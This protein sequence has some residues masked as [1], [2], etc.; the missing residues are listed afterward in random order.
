MDERGYPSVYVVD[1]HT[2]RPPPVPPRLG[3]K[4]QHPGAVQTL[5]FLLVSLAL[6]GMLIEAFLIYRLHKSESEAS[7]SHS[8]QSGDVD[9]YSK[10]SREVLPSKPVAHLTGGQDVVHKN[11]VM[12]W[13]RNPEPLLHEMD[14]KDRSLII[15]RQGYYNIYSKVSFFDINPFFHA[16]HVRTKL[17]KGKSIPLLVSRTNTHDSCRKEIRDQKSSSEEAS[18]LDGVD[19]RSNSYLSGVFHFF[20]DDAIFVKVSNTSQIVGLRAYEN[21]FG[22]YMI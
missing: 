7:G 6:C 4:R 15:Q 12:A 20:K 14:Y 16:I 10:G 3:Q 5:L 8:K 19:Q 2:P 11:Q 1:T 22:A 21:I 17:F 18:R 13:S 9:P